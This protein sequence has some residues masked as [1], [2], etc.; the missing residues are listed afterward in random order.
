MRDYSIR[1]GTAMTAMDD[2]WSLLVDSS[3]GLVDVPSG[4][5]EELG[6]PFN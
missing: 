6:A 5:F 3:D 1:S 4:V 2:E